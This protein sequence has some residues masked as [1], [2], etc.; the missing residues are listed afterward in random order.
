[1]S[2]PGDKPPDELGKDGQS[3]PANPASSKPTL[4]NISR[5]NTPYQALPK[6]SKP[7]IVQ[8]IPGIPAAG[9]Q[10][11]L[12]AAGLPQGLLPGSID[13]SKSSLTPGPL[14]FSTLAPTSTTP[15]QM[16]STQIVKVATPG[17]SQPSIVQISAPTPISTSSHV[18]DGSIL[19]HQSAFPSHL[20]RGPAAAASVLSAPKSNT[21]VPMG[22]P[23]HHV[24]PSSSVATGI[25][26]T[27]GSL[28]TS[29][30][31]RTTTPPSTRAISPAVSITSSLSEPFRQLKTVP[32]TAAGIQI[33]VQPSRTNTDLPPKQQIIT[34]QPPIQKLQLPHGLSNTKMLMSQ[35]PITQQS[36]LSAVPK[37]N[38]A[39]PV[40]STPYS[41]VSLTL[42]TTPSNVNSSPS[43]IPVAKVNPVRQQQPSALSSHLPTRPTGP[44]TTQDHQ[45]TESSSH[46][47]LSLPTPAPAH[48]IPH[49]QPQS[50]GLFLPQAHRQVTTAMTLPGSVTP[51]DTRAAAP[52]LSQ[53]QLQYMIT[54]EYQNLMYQQMAAAAAGVQGLPI[55]STPSV[56]PGIINQPSLS[57]IQAAVHGMLSSNQGIVDPST[58]MM[59]QTPLN[60]YAS[61]NVTN[62]FTTSTDANIR[63]TTPK[64]VTSVTVPSTS[65]VMTTAVSVSA[66]SSAIAMATS[67]MNNLSSAASNIYINNANQ[68]P[69]V[70]QYQTNQAAGVTQY[71]NCMPS[72]TPVTNANSS[73]RPTI[74]RKRT[75]EGMTVVKKPVCGLNTT[76]EK[77][78]VDRNSPR[79]D[80]RTDSAPQSN[81]SSPKTPATPAGESQSSTDTALSSEATTPT[82][83]ALSDLRIKQEPNDTVENGFGNSNSLPNSTETSPRKKP[84]KQLLHVNQEL[85]DS[86]SSDDDDF[87]DEKYDIK[88]D[89]DIKDEYYDDEGVRWTLEKTKPNIS[90]LNFYNISWK[91]RN[92]HFQRYSD[93]KQKDE[94]RPTVNELSNQ[95]GVMQKASGW[96]LY[97]MA[98]Q[99]EDLTAL[100]K[101]LHEK[102][103]DLQESIAP[104]PVRQHTPEDDSGLLHELTQANLQRSKLIADQLDE[105]KSSMLKVLDHKTKIFEIINKHMSKRPIK[106]KERS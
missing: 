57:T 30:P 55:S 51:T 24:M 97:H 67:N 20:P 91:S 53:L 11:I 59:R 45:R 64:D 69:G 39:L 77:L 27:R 65:V 7:V 68:T 40:S 98:A 73:P 4:T 5:V 87:E 18:V 76:Q 13:V 3:R 74:L 106:K 35:T 72:N 14:N 16:S 9:L 63:S 23:G 93:V 46:V 90:L 56:R 36:V 80:S 49:S 89:F 103:L 52:L 48:N 6:S 104:Q 95:R 42:T 71:Q 19:K 44:T 105:A 26:S 61:H 17:V 32:T 25:H 94:R 54:P 99:M 84:R 60:L 58:M 29:T 83:N 88:E 41:A 15:L 2:N 47:T 8:N 85:K 31:I 75:N 66:L 34:H 43:I 28:I 33:T 10:A 50:T 37:G 38:K 82:Q 100:E 86:S 62:S 70:Q 96:K 12:P 102:V 1:M 92:N 79:P 81:T 101:T 21:A 78:P 22:R